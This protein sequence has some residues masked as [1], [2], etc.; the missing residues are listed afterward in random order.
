MHLPVLEDPIEDCVG[1]EAIMVEQGQGAVLQERG[2]GP[3]GRA[4]P[5]RAVVVEGP[6]V[7]AG[8]AG[9]ALVPQPCGGAFRPHELFAHR[10]AE[11]L[12]RQVV[13]A[14]DG[15]PVVSSCD[16][17]RKYTAFYKKYK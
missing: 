4:C 12:A 11:P 17:R 3:C 9:A 10:F 7:V 16:A 8:V 15:V 13:A 2:R 1:D 5:P 14:A 6:D